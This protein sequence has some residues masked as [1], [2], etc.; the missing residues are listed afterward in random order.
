MEGVKISELAYFLF[1]PWRSPFQSHGKS[2]ILWHCVQRTDSHHQIPRVTW[3][4]LEKVAKMRQNG[5]LFHFKLGSFSQILLTN[6][7][8][9]K[10]STKPKSTSCVFQLETDKILKAEPSSKGLPLILAPF[11]TLS[12]FKDSH[13]S[14]SGCFFNHKPGLARSKHPFDLKNVFRRRFPKHLSQT[15]A[16]RPEHLLQIYRV[17]LP[18][19]TPV[20]QVLVDFQS[21]QFFQCGHQLLQKPVTALSNSFTSI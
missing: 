1:D 21:T 7:R 20:T 3:D 14:F 13:S 6:D 9:V 15:Q 11:K 18:F 16:R 12:L 8:I 17:T 2:K 10:T 4:G 5:F 19:K